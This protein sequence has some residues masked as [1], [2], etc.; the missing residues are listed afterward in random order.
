MMKRMQPIVMACDAPS[1]SERTAA[2]MPSDSHG[3]RCIWPPAR[4]VTALASVLIIGEEPNPSEPGAGR[5]FSCL[6]QAG[7]D[8]RVRGSLDP[9]ARGLP[10]GTSRRRRRRQPTAGRE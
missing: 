3:D 2:A 1:L 4:R 6:P 8:T 9:Q 10:E 7:T 5:V